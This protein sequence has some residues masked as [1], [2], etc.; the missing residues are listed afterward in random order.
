MTKE[1]LKLFLN[2]KPSYLKKGK[3]YLSNMFELNETDCELALQEVKQELK[4]KDNI[5]IKRLFFDIE[6]TPN[7]VYT[8]RAGYNI[9]ISHDSIIEERK[10]ISIHWKWQG[11]NKVHHLTWDKNQDDKE[12]LIAFIKVAN[13]AN[14]IIGHNGDRFDIKWLRTRCI[15]H[16]IPM[17][18]IYQ[19]LDTLKK[20]KKYFNF[21]SNKLDYIA[22]FLGVGA[23]TE[24][25]G[26]SLWL[27]VMKND[28]EALRKMV[29]YGD[30][31]VV[32]LE[33]IFQVMSSYINQNVHHGALADKENISC[34][35]CTEEVISYVKPIVTPLGTIQ[36]I[37]NCDSCNS[38]FKI[39]DSKFKKL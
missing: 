30:N 17:L 1:D 7:V 6:T 26:Y 11:E 18:P 29:I 32:I 3:T 8:W 37:M 20:A 38:T 22:Q 10:I 27:K 24:H 19:T 39:S 36:R 35:N 2:K 15:Y 16:R 34:P 9:T 25:E 12:M 21:N 33:D 4:S 28:K 31:D 5:K 13:S 14:E 23:K